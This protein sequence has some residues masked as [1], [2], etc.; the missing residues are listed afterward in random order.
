V[1]GN[2]VDDQFKVY[3]GDTG[4]FIRMLDDDTASD[5]LRGNM[6]S[7]KGAIFENVMADL[8]GKRGMKMYY[9][10][11]ESGLEIDFV[12]RYKGECTLVEVKA[13]N[14]NAKS[15]KTILAHY[16]KYHVKSAI[17]LGDYNVGYKDNLL[18][19]P[20]YMAFL[21]REY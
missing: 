1:C 10:H 11:K 7:Y 5:I 18:T 6:L 2:A 21:L 13:V 14:G 12:M 4:L 20:H 19:L 15:T 17:K 9:F 8:M 3:M 16:E